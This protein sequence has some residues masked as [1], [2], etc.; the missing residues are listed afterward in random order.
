MPRFFCIGAQKAGTTWLFTMLS[1]NRSYWFPPV[2]EVHYYDAAFF[3]PLKRRRTEKRLRE[4][5]ANARADGR[6]VS[7]AYIDAVLAAE[8]WSEEWYRR[9]YDHPDA[10]GRI[11]C[12][13]TPAYLGLGNPEIAALKHGNPGAKI[14]LLVRD[15]LS[16]MLSQL[17]MMRKRFSKGTFTDAEWQTLIDRLHGSDRANY[18]VFIPR[19][20]QHFGSENLMI[21]PFSV[22]RREP[23]DFL[24]RLDDFAGAARFAYRGADEKVHSEDGEPVPDHVRA[25]L[26]DIAREQE[27]Y[28][29]SEF[30]EEFFRQTL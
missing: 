28:L 9:L 14:L 1:Q 10:Q 7:A 17:K 30:G 8:P 3:P 16:R 21:E 2:K 15:P 13:I 19:W 23:R 11:T 20:K 6:D 4:Y 29:I 24:D 5:G 26:V 27:A 22:I 25:G 12:D 18:K